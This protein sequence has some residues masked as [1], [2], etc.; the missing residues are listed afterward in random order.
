MDIDCEYTEHVV[1]CPHCGFEDQDW[2]DGWNDDSEGY[3]GIDYVC[4]NCESVFHLEWE[5][6]RYFTSSKKVKE[7][8]TG[9]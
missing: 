2:W 4:G 7:A 3:R 8:L 6:T 1:V 5:D 9:V